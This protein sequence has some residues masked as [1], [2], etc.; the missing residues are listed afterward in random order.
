MLKLSSLYTALLLLTSYWLLS[1]WTFTLYPDTSLAF[2]SIFSDALRHAS[3]MH[4]IASA[5][6]P[7]RVT[8]YSDEVLQEVRRH[9]LRTSSNVKLNK[10]YEALREWG[11]L[12]DLSALASNV[13]HAFRIFPLQCWQPYAREINYQWSPS[14][15]TLH[16]L[17]F[18][19]QNAT[20]FETHRRS[21]ALNAGSGIVIRKS[22]NV[23]SK[24]QKPQNG[25]V[26]SPFRVSLLLNYRRS[27]GEFS[28]PRQVF[29]AANNDTARTNES[30][31]HLTRDCASSSICHGW[32][33]F[34][35][36]E[37]MEHVELRKR[38]VRSEPQNAPE[39]GKERAQFESGVASDIGKT[40]EQMSAESEIRNSEDFLGINRQEIIIRHRKAA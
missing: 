16:D 17:W 25:R 39:T 7:I 4:D 10:F 31:I 22:S 28:R 40:R 11:S 13:T 26:G 5:S 15:A 9:L 29:F 37:S 23:P 32:T 3:N 36:L 6:G 18:L 1:R 24:L 2:T 35:L 8:A 21:N 30:S 20:D 27:S 34:P 12:S 38:E 33:I 14:F 19:S